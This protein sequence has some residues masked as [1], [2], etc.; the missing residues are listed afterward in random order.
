MICSEKHGRSYTRIIIDEFIKNGISPTRL[1]VWEFEKPRSVLLKR[2]DNA[3]STIVS[4]EVIPQY[5]SKEDLEEASRYSDFVTE[6]VTYV[7][8]YVSNSFNHI[9]SFT[10]GTTIPR[11]SGEIDLRVLPM[12]RVVRKIIRLESIASEI[13]S[14]DRVKT[15]SWKSLSPW[16][17]EGLLNLQSQI[18]VLSKEFPTEF[19]PDDPAWISDLLELEED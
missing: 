11:S 5:F 13:R 1:A 18:G 15:D 6:H 12:S 10:P 17:Y 16:S 2:L 7:R 8:I 3:V 4:G 14:L 9:H 19:Y